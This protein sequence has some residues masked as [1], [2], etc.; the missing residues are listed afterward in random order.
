MAV[1]IKRGMLARK[2]SLDLLDGLDMDFLTV[3]YD[4]TGK[5]AQGSF[6]YQDDFFLD[7]SFDD[8]SGSMG[9]GI[10]GQDSGSSCDQEVDLDLFRHRRSSSISNSLMGDGSFDLVGGSFFDGLGSYI[11]PPPSSSRKHS[12]S[13]PPALTAPRSGFAV[14]MGTGGEV[15]MSAY[16]SMAA[17]LQAQSKANGQVLRREER[18]ENNLLCDQLHSNKVDNIQFYFICSKT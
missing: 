9:M 10:M 2:Q 18:R 14:G 17:S 1:L 6:P 12:L 13:L 15:D 8:R 11:L 7:H 5:G 4:G 3:G 16:Q